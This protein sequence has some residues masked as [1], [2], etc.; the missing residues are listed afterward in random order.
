M[1]TINYSLQDAWIGTAIYTW[2]LLTTA[3]ADGQPAQYQ[4]VG[5]RVIQIT[6]TF[7]AGGTVVLQGSTDGTNWYG[8]KNPSNTAISFTAPGLSAVL[9]N[10]PYIRPFVSAGDGT[11]AITAQLAVRRRNQN[12]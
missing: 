12:D 3:N 11:T 4:G 9:E 1:A 10:C 2:L 6:G 8:L 5:D 7:G